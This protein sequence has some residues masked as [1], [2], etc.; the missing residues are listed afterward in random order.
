MIQCEKCG[1]QNQPIFR[2]CLKCGAELPRPAGAAPGAAKAAKKAPEKPKR[3]ETCPHCSADLAEGRRFCVACGREAVPEAERGPRP[4]V[5]RLV[6]IRPDGSDG[7]SWPLYLG[8]TALGNGAGDHVFTE[9]EMMSPRHADFL[10]EAG[11]V[12]LFDRGSTSGTFVRVIDAVPLPDGAQFRV[13]QQ[14]L[15][16]DQSAVGGD[17]WGE[18][19]RLTGAEGEEVERYP[20]EGENVF[21]GRERG[22]ITFAEDGYVSGS[23]AVLF[24][25]DGVVHIKDLDSS[26][27]TYVRMTEPMQLTTGRLVLIGAHLFRVEVD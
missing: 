16:I 19:A 27:G 5:G 13:G 3:V 24:R 8:V 14:L 7:R 20:L 4:E 21:V 6:M 9:D 10:V 18:V 17:R 26:N 11:E 1:N 25:Q 2:F 23:H 15:Q 22:H 12:R